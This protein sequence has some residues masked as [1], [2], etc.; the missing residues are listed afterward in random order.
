MLIVVLLKK[1]WE[2]LFNTPSYNEQPHKHKNRPR[3]QV[4][5]ISD[6][7]FNINDIKILKRDY[8]LTPRELSMFHHLS[9]LLTGRDYLVTPKIPL[10]ALCVIPENAANRIEFQNRLKTQYVDYLICDKSTLKPLM[11]VFIFSD[12]DSKRERS[13][14]KFSY[15]IALAADMT[16]VLLNVDDEREKDNLASQL[17]ERG[18]I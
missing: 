4:I 2:K 17:K 14:N 18:I 9:D 16:A 7:S 6:L 1:L 10:S 3:G 5:D 12:N 15:R 11:L 13:S 8:L